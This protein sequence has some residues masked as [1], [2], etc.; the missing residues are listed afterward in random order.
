[1]LFVLCKTQDSH[2]V[3]DSEHIVEIIR[4]VQITRLPSESGRL[5]GLLNYR[6]DMIPVMDSNRFL[7]LPSAPYG[8]DSAILVLRYANQSFAIVLNEV[9][10]VMEMPTDALATYEVMDNDYFNSAL[11]IEGKIHPVLNIKRMIQDI[12]SSLQS[13]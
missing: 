3:V 9:I 13:V 1:M 11:Q 4:M 10:N 12:R 6:G 2:F 7:Q 8:A 5:D